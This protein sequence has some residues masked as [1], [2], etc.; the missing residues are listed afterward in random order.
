MSVDLE[1]RTEA[2]SNLVEDSFSHESTHGR[3]SSDDRASDL[4]GGNEDEIQAEQRPKSTAPGVLI[5]LQEGHVQGPWCP[6][7]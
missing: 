1:M 7:W 6:H 3:I 5:E 2:R 4:G